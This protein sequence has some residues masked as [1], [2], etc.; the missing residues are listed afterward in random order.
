[1][2]NNVPSSESNIQISEIIVKNNVKYEKFFNY[3]KDM[4]VLYESL[5]YKPPVL[6]HLIQN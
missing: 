6:I 4:N 3:L 1:M 2:K 5:G